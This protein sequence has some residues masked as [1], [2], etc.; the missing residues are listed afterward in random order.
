MNSLG[1]LSGLL[2]VFLPP[3]I[4]VK[5]ISLHSFRPIPSNLVDRI[6]LSLN[7]LH[8]YIYVTAAFHKSWKHHENISIAMLNPLMS[9]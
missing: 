6:L 2:S 9:P 7:K 4:Q 1:L 5:R 3:P 8:T